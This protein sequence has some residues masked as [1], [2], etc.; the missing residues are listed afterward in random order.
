MLNGCDFGELSW[1]AAGDAIES[2]SDLVGSSSFS[3]ESLA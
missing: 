3:S 1:L 2:E